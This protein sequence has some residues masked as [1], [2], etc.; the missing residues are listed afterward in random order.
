MAI[1]PTQVEI[2]HEVFSPSEEEIEY[3]RGLLEA[4]REGEARGLGAVKYRGM[5]VDYA[6]VRLAER[7]LSLAGC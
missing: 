2:M 1:H 5:M 3:A 7:T 6:N 4:F